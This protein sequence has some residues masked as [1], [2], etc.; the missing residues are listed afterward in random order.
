M[1][2]LAFPIQG[3]PTLRH[4][5]VALPG[6][7]V[8]PRDIYCVGGDPRGH[9]TPPDIVRVR[10]G[11]VLG[12][13][14]IAQEIGSR[15]SRQGS[16]DGSGDVI[17]T[18]ADIG[19]QGSKDVKGGAVAQAFL[20]DH[21]GLNLV[22]GNMTRALDDDLDTCVPCSFGQFTQDDQF[23]HLGRVGGV[24]DAAWPE[25]VPEADGDIMLTQ[26]LHQLVVPLV[27]GVLLLLPL[28]PGGQHGPSAAYNTRHPASF[29]HCFHRRAGD[30]AVHGDKVDPILGMA[31]DSVNHVVAGQ[32]GRVPFR[33]VGTDSRVV[34][35]H[36][37]DRDRGPFDNFPAQFIHISACG[38][39]HDGIGTG[40]DSGIELFKLQFRVVARKA[41]S[42][43]SV[44]LYFERPPYAAGLKGF[45]ARVGRNSRLAGGQELQN[46]GFFHIFICR[47]MAHDISDT[48]F[49]CF[50]SLG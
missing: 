37:A 13:G 1:G 39:V 46:F 15:H 25:A 47:H 17:V 43:V 8:A 42:D 33:L 10:Q 30:A 3:R 21:V 50:D 41:G 22:K 18:R 7:L 5:E 26:D 31:P 35:G 6:R 45:V 36:C 19:D 11:K 12:R 38:Q 48:S 29:T 49:Q 23:F 32:K 9:D 20:K 44:D 14:D 2:D 28:H 4:G 27:E 16:A 24:R 40:L 34:D